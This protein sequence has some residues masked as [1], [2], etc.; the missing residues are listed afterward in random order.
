MP[1]LDGQ[2]VVHP[3]DIFLNE[4]D[5]IHVQKI[6]D[7]KNFLLVYPHMTGFTTAAVAWAVCTRPRVKTKIKSIPFNDVHVPIPLFLFRV[8]ADTV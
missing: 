7:L 6:A 3:V 1:F 5:G 4:V 2:S 8:P